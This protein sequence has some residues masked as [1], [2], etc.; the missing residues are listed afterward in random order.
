MLFNY[1]CC[2]TYTVNSR[3]HAGQLLLITLFLDKPPRDSL[4]V[5]SAHSFASNGQHALL[6]SAE[7]GNN[8][9]SKIFA[10]SGDL[11]RCVCIRSAHPTD[12]AR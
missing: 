3:G 12:R 6:L 11:L 7:E 5:I 8:F 4:P 10:E 1:M 2:F 9:S